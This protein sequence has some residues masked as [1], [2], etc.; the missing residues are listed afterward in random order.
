M[1]EM[2]RVRERERPP[3]KD[4]PYERVLRQ[5]KELKERGVLDTLVP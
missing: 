1:A 3:L 2:E 5:R 4:N